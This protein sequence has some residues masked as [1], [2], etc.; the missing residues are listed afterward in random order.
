MDWTPRL[1]SGP[2]P[3]RLRW[4]APPPRRREPRWSFCVGTK[5]EVRSTP[6]P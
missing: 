6:N 2:G 4:T 3:G 1:A 5:G